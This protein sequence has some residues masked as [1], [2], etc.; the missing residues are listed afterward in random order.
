MLSQLSEGDERSVYEARGG[1]RGRGRGQRKEGG[2]AKGRKGEG[3]KEGRRRGQR[4]REGNFVLKTTSDMR[5][6]YH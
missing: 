3:P 1:A 5:C 4:R 2:G 6:S